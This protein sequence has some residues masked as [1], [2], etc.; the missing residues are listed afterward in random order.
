MANGACY[1]SGLRFVFRINGFLCKSTCACMSLRSE[2]RC[3]YHAIYWSLFYHS[4]STVIIVFG[5]HAVR[6]TL[7]ILS[8]ANREHISRF[9]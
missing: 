8:N 4:C 5:R 6:P 3:E 7:K 9:S 2:L 1:L